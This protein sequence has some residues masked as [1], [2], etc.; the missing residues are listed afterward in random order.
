MT[1]IHPIAPATRRA[2]LRG[3][4]AAAALATARGAH[5]QSWPAGKPIRLVLPSGAG[6]GADSF[7]RFMAEWLSKELATNVIVENKPGATSMLAAQDVARAA[8]DGYTLLIMGAGATVSNKLMKIKPP[9]DPVD[10]LTAIARIGGRGGNM[11]AVNPSLPVK[12]VKELV[13]Y[14]KTHKE[15]SYASWGI[16]SG[17]HLVMESIKQQSGMKIEHVPY[18]TEAQIPTDLI[19]GVIM[20]ATL[21]PATPVPYIRSGRI[22]AIG[23]FSGERLPQFK[24]VP[25]VIEQGFKLDAF[26]WFGLYGPKGMPRDLVERLNATLN[27]WMVLPEVVEFLEGKQNTPPPIPMSVAEFEKFI[28]QELVT[29]KRLLDSAGIKPE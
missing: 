8:P 4:A 23:T 9:I 16:G 24:D 6:G 5:A 27:K 22:R 20:V 25:T 2:V 12:S 26:P 10:A 3:F 17:G 7:G 11:L 21:G 29:W 18:K 28:Q 14:T 13:E 19:S 1:P 15:L